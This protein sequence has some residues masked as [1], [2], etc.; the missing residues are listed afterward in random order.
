MA[1]SLSGTHIQRV[2]HSHVAS[3]LPSVSCSRGTIRRRSFATVWPT[4]SGV[5]DTIFAALAAMMPNIDKGTCAPNTYYVTA[6]RDCELPSVV[7]ICARETTLS[8]ICTCTLLSV[9]CISRTSRDSTSETYSCTATSWCTG[10]CCNLGRSKAAYSCQVPC[11]YGYTG[12]C[13]CPLTPSSGHADSSSATPRETPDHYAAVSCMAAS[14]A[15]A[16]K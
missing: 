11:S 12:G 9:H 13:V 7:A 5:C 15:A 16:S 8:F 1:R 3:F 14:I 6:F 2:T 4:P 10:A